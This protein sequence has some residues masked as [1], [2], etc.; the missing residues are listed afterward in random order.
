MPIVVRISWHISPSAR[1]NEQLLNTTL[2]LSIG[3]EI[4]SNLLGYFNPNRKGFPFR[5]RT[6]QDFF[7]QGPDSLWKSRKKG[8]CECLRTT[9]KSD[10][11]MKLQSH[12]LKRWVP[13]KLEK[14]GTQQLLYCKNQSISI[15]SI[16]SNQIRNK[17]KKR[18]GELKWTSPT[19][20]VFEVFW[21]CSWRSSNKIRG[22]D[23]PQKS[24]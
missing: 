8:G 24:I 13:S 4:I 20:P 21:K 2:N 19:F 18:K 6:I 11:N 5:R 15:K 14:S 22:F 3:H 12:P 17:I 10:C 16:E 7:L 23:V 1:G 9:A